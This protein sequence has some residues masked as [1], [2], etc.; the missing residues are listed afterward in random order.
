MIVVPTTDPNADRTGNILEALCAASSDIVIPKMFEIVTKI[1]HTRD[2]ESAA[3]IDIA[4]SNKIFDASHWLTLTGYN[5]LIRSI[6]KE[7]QNNSG[8]YIA[9]YH[10]KAEKELENYIES[11]EKLKK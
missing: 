9:V 8:G 10:D 2:E 6:I 11:Y 5:A 7:G 1:Q 4:L 3:M